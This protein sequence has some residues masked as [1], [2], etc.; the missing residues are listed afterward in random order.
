MVL[1]LGEGEGEGAGGG[2]GAGAGAGAG[3]GEPAS[4]SASL[5]RSV[6][7][8]GSS[9]HALVTPHRHLHRSPAPQPAVPSSKPEGRYRAL[10][11]D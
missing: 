11:F 8:A 5:A 6:W 7:L 4:T 9:S 3:A 2:E 1:R 10:G